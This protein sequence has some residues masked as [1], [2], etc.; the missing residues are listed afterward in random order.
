MSKLKDDL[1]LN[2]GKVPK[3]YKQPHKEL[4]KDEELSYEQCSNQMIEL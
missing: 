1:E 4:I 3:Y 2:E